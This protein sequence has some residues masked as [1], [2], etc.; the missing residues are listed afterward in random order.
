MQPWT[1]SQKNYLFD[2]L[3]KKSISQ[4]AEGV[5]KSEMA[6]NLYLHRH[7][8][9]PR[10]NSK[11]HNLLI[12]LLEK[13]FK[14]VAFFTPTR[15]FFDAVVIGQKRYWAMFKGIEPITDEELVR[16]AEYLDFPLEDIY[17]IRQLKLF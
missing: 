2:N 14:D 7:R 1:K 9:D 11:K 10:L 16:I 3:N 13:K 8:N 12:M 17:E 4:I 15:K 6:V 5:H